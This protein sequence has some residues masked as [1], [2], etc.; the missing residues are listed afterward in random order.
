MLGPTGIGVLYGRRALLEE[1]PPVVGGGD[2][3][4]KVTL[5]GS[6]WNDLPWKFEAGTPAIAEAI[7]LGAAA[8]YLR[9]VGMDRVQAHERELVGYALERLAAVP[10]V[11]VYGPRDPAE[12]G[13][14]ISFNVGDVHPHDVA[15]VLDGAG[16]AIRAGHHCAQPLMERLDVPATSRASVA[17]YNTREEIDRLIDGLAIVKR[18]FG[19]GER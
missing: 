2:M 16:I 14:A 17:L 4:R 3:I 10:N 15:S 9:R 7:G 13:G 6:T 12:H 1:M 11:T 8:D 19:I 5:Q 18:I